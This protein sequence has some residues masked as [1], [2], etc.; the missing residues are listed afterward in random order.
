[1]Q[2]KEH[3]SSIKK[4]YPQPTEA[5]KAP[6]R[7]PSPHRKKRNES[8]ALPTFTQIVQIVDRRTEAYPPSE[9]W[10]ESLTNRED[11]RG[12]NRPVAAHRSPT[13]R[14]GVRGGETRRRGWKRRGMRRQR[15]GVSP[16]DWNSDYAI[17]FWMARRA[18]TENLDFWSCVF[19]NK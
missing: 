17:P 6:I 4:Q 5:M 3:S 10:I 13:R 1:M 8:I 18:P 7:R 11:S 12:T 14:G 19:H 16:R 9:K 15:G 2:L